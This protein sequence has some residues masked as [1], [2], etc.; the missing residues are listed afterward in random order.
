[1]CFQAACLGAYKVLEQYGLYRDKWTLELD[2]AL[3]R[4]VAG[5]VIDSLDVDTGGGAANS[6]SGGQPH[7]QAAALAVRIKAVD[8]VA[9]ELL[10]N[11]EALL[12]KDVMCALLNP[13]TLPTKG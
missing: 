5:M 1:M 2:K 10:E 8:I 11:A 9:E 4:A 6:G 12:P 3:A 13:I 7:I